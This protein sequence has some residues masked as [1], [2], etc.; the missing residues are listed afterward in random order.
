MLTHYILVRRDLPLGVVAAMI[1][2]AAGE[3]GSRYCDCYDG[4]FRGARAVV[5]GFA[6][7]PTLLRAAEKLRRHCID[8][9]RVNESDDPYDG[10][11]MAVGVVPI[12][13]DTV[14]V[15]GKTVAQVMRPFQ[16]LKALD[17]QDQYA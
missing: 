3:S 13:P 5:L 1:T 12:D 7:E 16:T 14:C 2:H 9:V 10:A 15:P 6:D 11:L 4:G 8:A 17:N